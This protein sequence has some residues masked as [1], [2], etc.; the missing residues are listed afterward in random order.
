VGEE[1]APSLR[2]AVAESDVL[3]ALMSPQFF[4]SKWCQMELSTALS[5]D[6]RIIPVLLNG[7]ITGPLSYLEYVESEDGLP[8]IVAEIGR[9]LR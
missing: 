1:F 8:A 7:E 5:N 2:D 6:K 9:S 4:R 3:V